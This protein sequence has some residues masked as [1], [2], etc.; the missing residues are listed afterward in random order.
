MGGNGP[1]GAGLFDAKATNGLGVRGNVF[2]SRRIV[3]MEQKLSGSEQARIPDSLET[4]MVARVQQEMIL[5]LERTLNSKL[6]FEPAQRSVIALVFAASLTAVIS[7][8]SIKFFGRLQIKAFLLKTGLWGRLII[9]GVAMLSE[10]C[11]ELLPMYFLL[12]DEVRAI[13]YHEVMGMEIL[14]VGFEAEDVTDS[15]NDA[16]ILDASS[17]FVLVVSKNTKGSV[18]VI[19]ILTTVLTVISVCVAV[20]S[21]LK[22]GAAMIASN[23]DANFVEISSSVDNYKARDLLRHLSSR[24]IGQGESGNMVSKKEAVE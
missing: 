20:H 18:F 13:R 3:L 10:L 9:G 14:G 21:I 5:S 16:P 11:L 17:G 1:N 2:K 7:F 22:L 4:S 23:N 8:K 12:A 6:R 15:A 24:S 19:A